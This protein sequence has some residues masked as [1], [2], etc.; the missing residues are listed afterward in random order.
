[1]R[2]QSSAISTVHLIDILSLSA[3]IPVPVKGRARDR[4]VHLAIFHQFRQMSVEIS[5]G[6]PLLSRKLLEETQKRAKSYLR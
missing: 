4:P 5:L 1:M 3:I 6:F 2:N